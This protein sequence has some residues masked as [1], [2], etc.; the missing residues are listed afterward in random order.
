MQ[1]EMELSDLAREYSAEDIVHLDA[2][3]CRGCSYCC[4]NVGRSIVLDPYD[5]FRLC[6]GSGRSFAQLLSEGLLEIHITEG[7]MLPNLSMRGGRGC[8]FLEAGRCTIH[9]ARP[10]FCRLFPLA[11]IYHEGGFSYIVQSGQCRREL[12]G[13]RRI[14]DWIGEAEPARYDRFLLSWHDFRKALSMRIPE[15]TMR[16]Q[17]MLGTY[18]LRKFYQTAYSDRDFYSEYEERLQRAGEAVQRLY[19]K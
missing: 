17:R 12:T 10:G 1:R 14:A 11:R 5:C 3:G 6:C 9:S 4:E 18:L 7:L 13:L 19:G 16:A 15:M 8:G 2:G